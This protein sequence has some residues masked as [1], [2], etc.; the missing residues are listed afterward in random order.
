MGELSELMKL[1]KDLESAPKNLA[2]HLRKAIERTSVSVK[3]E[4]QGSVR[5]RSGFGHAASAIDYEL[6]GVAG[7]SV[8]EMRSEVGY[9]RA[10]R[11]GRLGNL[12]EFGAPRAK[13]HMLVNG[14]NV[15]V[16]GSISQP[17]APSHDLGNALLNNE[18]DFVRGVESAVDDAMTEAGL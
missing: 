12:I 9:N 17:L 2:P 16:P 7:K 4:A 5:Q 13:K 8:S 6:S 15:P 14:R 1:A 11:A 3:K 10:K 18:E